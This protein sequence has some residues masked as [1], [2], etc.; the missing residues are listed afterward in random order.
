MNNSEKL[1]LSEIREKMRCL[2]QTI[3][4]CEQ[5]LA[6]LALQYRQVKGDELSDIDKN[7]IVALHCNFKDNAIELISR[8]T[9]FPMYLVQSVIEK[10]RF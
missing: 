8:K 9:G 4:E 2:R 6:D 7:M 1:N 10:H 5:E 3:S